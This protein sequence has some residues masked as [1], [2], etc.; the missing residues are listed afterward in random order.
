VIYSSKEVEKMDN[1]KAKWEYTRYGALIIT[2]PDGKEV[3]VQQDV[4]EV[5]GD[6]GYIPGDVYPG[7]W[8]YIPDDWPYWGEYYWIAQLPGEK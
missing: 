4:I 3:F 2:F 7:D 1:E 5:L 6:L 8:D